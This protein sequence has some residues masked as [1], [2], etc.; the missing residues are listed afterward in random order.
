MINTI[1]DK[2]ILLEIH[3]VKEL[4]YKMIFIKSIFK[5]NANV[6]IFNVRLMHLRNAINV[7]KGTTYKIVEDTYTVYDISESHKS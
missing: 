5:K 2:Y 1:Y 3:F 7:V 4:F 6:I